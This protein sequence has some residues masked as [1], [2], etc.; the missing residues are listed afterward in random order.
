MFV[1]P[2]EAARMLDGFILGAVMQQDPFLEEFGSLPEEPPDED[3]CWDS[4]P[5]EE[6]R[7]EQGT[8]F[9]EPA[10]QQ[11]LTPQ[12]VSRPIAKPIARAE[13]EPRNVPQ[14]YKP[15]H[16][17]YRDYLRVFNGSSSLALYWFNKQAI[18]T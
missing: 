13:P 12:P 15:K 3:P 10:P 8:L 18:K 17:P 2:Q 6:H 14:P 9:D 4:K 16:I 5:N 1:S 11:K 7:I